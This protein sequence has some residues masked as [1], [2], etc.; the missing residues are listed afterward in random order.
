MIVA[1]EAAAMGIWPAPMET[2]MDTVTSS[3]TATVIADVLAQSAQAEVVV[4]ND[5]AAVTTANAAPAAKSNAG[6][7][8]EDVIA[9]RKD[10][11]EWVVGAYARSNAA[12]YTLMARCLDAYQ[13]M[14][15]KP[16]QIS[17]FHMECERAGLS[18]KKTTGV[19]Q[20]IVSFVFAGAGRRRTSAYARV[21]V[22]AHATNIVPDELH[23]WIAREGGVEE[24][25][26]KTAKGP[27]AKQKMDA[28]VAV[29]TSAI[30]AATPFTVIQG[31]KLD[32][33]E[34][35]TTFVAALA[36]T[37]ADGSLEVIGF[38]TDKAAVNAVMAAYGEKVTVKGTADARVTDADSKVEAL[39]AAAAA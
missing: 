36:R 24:I 39:A 19:L 38:V 32:M 16:A 17:A 37:T 18:F 14:V 33:T 8:V 13:R 9:I 10:H 5:I 3:V 31:A 11:D 2:T 22:R 34:A 4:S 29:A 21:L 20:R 7:P 1:P 27:T 15:G 26:G 12:L 35:S 25:R 28:N 23:I 30:A 6:M